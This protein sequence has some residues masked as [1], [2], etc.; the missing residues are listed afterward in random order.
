MRM[1]V[2][3]HNGEFRGCVKPQPGLQGSQQGL[4]LLL[5]GQAVPAGLFLSLGK[6]SRLGVQAAESVSRISAALPPESRFAR[7]A[8]STAAVALRNTA[9]G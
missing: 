7:S 3:A 9:S 5:P 6:P 2:A 8:N 1:T 4:F